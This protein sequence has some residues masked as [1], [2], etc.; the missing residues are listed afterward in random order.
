[1]PKLTVECFVQVSVEVYVYDDD[2][3]TNLVIQDAIDQATE[4]IENDL[5]IKS[6]SYQL[7]EDEY[8]VYDENGK[9]LEEIEQD[10]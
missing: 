3:D 10:A 5:D 6:I 7:P 8:Y 9:L 4:I 1:M 2:M